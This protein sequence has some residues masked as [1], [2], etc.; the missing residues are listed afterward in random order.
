MGPLHVE[1]D[2][3][4]ITVRDHVVFPFDL[5]ATGVLHR[6]LGPVLG[7]DGVGDH[8]GVLLDRAG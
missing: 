4:N 5:Q 2:V 7:E 1:P 8:L 3:Q 6:L